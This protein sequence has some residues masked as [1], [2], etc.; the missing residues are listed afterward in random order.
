[1]GWPITFKFHHLANSTMLG[2]LILQQYLNHNGSYGLPSTCNRKGYK[3]LFRRSSHIYAC[4]GSHHVQP[5]N[6]HIW[7][8]QRLMEHKGGHR[9]VRAWRMHC[10]Y[11]GM[12]KAHLDRDEV[13][14]NSEKIK[15]IALAVIELCLSQDISQTISPLEENLLK[16]S[17]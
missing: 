1:M 13:M 11:C 15:V 16:W 2:D 14:L 5:P 8:Q 10:A 6:W 12:P 9:L 17:F 4:K 7:C 3:T